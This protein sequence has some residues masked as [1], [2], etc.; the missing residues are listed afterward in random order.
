MSDFA[1]NIWKYSNGSMRLF[2]VDRNAA[3]TLQQRL[4][5]KHDAY[6]TGSSSDVQKSAVECHLCWSNEMLA[7]A[8]LVLEYYSTAASLAQGGSP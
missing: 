4:S 5:L 1:L 6:C 8:I 2:G 3:E 7:W